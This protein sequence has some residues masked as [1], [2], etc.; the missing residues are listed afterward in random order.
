[1]PATNIVISSALE[2]STIDFCENIF[3]TC[4]S[5]QR[6]RP[7]RMPSYTIKHGQ[8]KK[9]TQRHRLNTILYSTDAASLIH[10]NWLSGASPSLFFSATRRQA[11]HQVTNAC[12]RGLAGFR[13]RNAFDQKYSLRNT[14]RGKVGAQ[15]REDGSRR[16]DFDI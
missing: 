7:Q 5:E 14:V 3:L 1:M 8:R 11:H 10:I 9:E 12:S 13:C 16:K 2:Q 4:E 6:D 15:K